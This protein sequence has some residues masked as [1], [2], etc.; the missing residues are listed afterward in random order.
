MYCVTAN[1]AEISSVH[2]KK[3]IYVWKDPSLT[4]LKEEYQRTDL[5]IHSVRMRDMARVLNVSGWRI[6]TEQHVFAVVGT[7]SCKNVFNR[8]VEV[9]HRIE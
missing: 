6:L 2:T 4:F 9:R 5:I 1:Q 8:V 3:L 7:I